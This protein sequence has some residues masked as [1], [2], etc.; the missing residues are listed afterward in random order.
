MRSIAGVSCALGAASHFW[1][2]ELVEHV[3]LHVVIRLL[4]TRPRKTEVTQLHLALIVNEDVG[5][6]YVAVQ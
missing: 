1:A 3:L 5:W 4:G 6:L 2:V